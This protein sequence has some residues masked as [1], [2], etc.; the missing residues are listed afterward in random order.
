ME[1]VDF[2]GYANTETQAKRQEQTYINANNLL[3]E[4]EY[5]EAITLF[6]QLGDYKDSKEL[7][8]T[9]ISLQLQEIEDYKSS[10][11]E[12]GYID[13]LDYVGSIDVKVYAQVKSHIRNSEYYIITENG[14]TIQIWNNSS[15]EELIEGEWITIYGSAYGHGDNMTIRV[16]YI[17]D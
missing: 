2:E 5:E 10:C 14:E 17:D 6:E 4:G 12:I 16:E 8:D 3:A 9:A 11:T 7:L 1:Y 15:R 13:D